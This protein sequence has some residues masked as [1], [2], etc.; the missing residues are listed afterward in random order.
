MDGTLHPAFGG[1]D[2]LEGSKHPSASVYPR[3]AAGKPAPLCGWLVDSRGKLKFKKAMNTAL[4]A[5]FILWVIHAVNWILPVDLRYFGIRPRSVDGLAGILWA[6]FLHG[7]LRH[8]IANSGALFVLLTV[9]TAYNRR[10]AWRAVAFIVAVGGLMVWVFG[11]PGA[12]HIGASGVVFG[13]IGFLLAVGFFRREWVA[14]MVSVLV[15][16][17]YGGALLSLLSPVPG[18]S[19]SSHFFGFLSGVLA[20]WW[21][22]ARA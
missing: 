19:W 5:V 20:A 7:N 6:P 14:L 8:L 4:T 15:L 13:L 2:S 10:L 3:P 1:D 16:V 17:L 21:T 18:V 9:A 11:N 22:R 12:V